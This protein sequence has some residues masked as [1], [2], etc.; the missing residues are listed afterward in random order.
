LKYVTNAFF[1]VSNEKYTKLNSKNVECIFL[2]YYKWTKCYTLFNLENKKIV[3]SWDFKFIKVW[4]TKKNESIVE[5]SNEPIEHII[6]VENFI[7]NEDFS[8]KLRNESKDKVG[9][10]VG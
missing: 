3:K 4:K 10:V 7:D 5:V 6:K 2:G 8:L 9:N 1:H